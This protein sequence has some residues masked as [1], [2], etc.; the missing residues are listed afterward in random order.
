M[1][2]PLIAILTASL[3]LTA[4]SGVRDSRLNPFNWFGQ[5]QET[6]ATTVTASPQSSDPRPLVAQ[7]SAVAV[8][9]IPGGAILRATG[10]PTRQGHWDAGLVAIP[11]DEPGLS[12]YEFRA[13][14]PLTAT[15]AGTPQSREITVGLYLS[16]Q[17]LG[18]IRTIVV[19]GA[20]NQQTVRR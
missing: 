18:P 6:R 8:D 4:C 9:R 11:N 17:D 10:L 5:A 13:A 12:I 14:A 7:V 19:R 15:A 2:A 3:A 1:R 20:Q 16:D